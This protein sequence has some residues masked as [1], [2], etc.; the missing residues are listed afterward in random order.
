MDAIT[1]YFDHYVISARVKPAFFVV[2]PLAVT[3]MAWWPDAKE[4]GGATLTFLVSF[5]VIGFLSNL[6]SN[7]GNKLQTRLFTEWGGAPTT[8]LL[9]HS[10]DTLDKH[11]KGRYHRQLENQIQGLK[12][13]TRDEELADPV[14]AD[15][16]YTSATNFLREHTR[17]K[18]QYPM[19][20]SD[21][22]AY[23]YARNLL[24][25]KFVGVLSAVIALALN[26]LWLTQKIQFSSDVQLILQ[27][28]IEHTLAAGAFAVSMVMMFLFVFVVNK[29]YVRGRAIRY[30]LSLHAVCDKKDMVGVG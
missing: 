19:I 12:I 27:T 20:Y 29:D 25:M 4:L 30:A 3:V 6:I 18:K 21:N 7:R 16:C 15:S 8:M 5:G 23:G 13:P 26:A 28:L 10:D 2:L 11:T 17:D 14:N 24:A 22:V 9:R 1:Q